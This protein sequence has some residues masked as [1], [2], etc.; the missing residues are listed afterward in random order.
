VRPLP[1]A[2]RLTQLHIGDEE[3]PKNAAQA[4]VARPTK[5]E[6]DAAAKASP[7]EQDLARLR[8]E[9]ERRRT[10]IELDG[11]TPDAARLHKY[12][13]DLSRS[14]L[15]AAAN[16][17]SLEAATANQQGQTR[18]TL[19]LIVRPSLVQTGG[20]TVASNPGVANAPRPVS[21]AGG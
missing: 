12:L 20:E 9:I 17:K 1:P 13:A 8:E 19:R 7:P 5:P 4:A 3:Q 16:I 14:P 18:F 15:I 21:G 10:V 6:E 11:L 2:I